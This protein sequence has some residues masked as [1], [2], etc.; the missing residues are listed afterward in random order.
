[1]QVL[2]RLNWNVIDLVIL[3]LRNVMDEKKSIS[4]VLLAY[5]SV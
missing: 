4:I 2:N 1:M 3:I 5:M